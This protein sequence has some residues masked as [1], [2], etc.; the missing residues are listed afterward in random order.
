MWWLF[1]FWASLIS[2]ISIAPWPE[3]A[4]HHCWESRVRAGG[5][6]SR[7]VARRGSSSVLRLTNSCLVS[8]VYDSQQSCWHWGQVREMWLFCSLNRLNV[9][10]M[11]LVCVLSRV[12]HVGAH[13]SMHLGLPVFSTEVIQMAF[14]CELATVGTSKDLT[15]WG[16]LY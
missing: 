7:V 12:Q 3:C 11:L 15:Q 14:M 4:H 9:W 16:F 10:K 1:L 13:D 2:Q 8:P 6:D 5:V